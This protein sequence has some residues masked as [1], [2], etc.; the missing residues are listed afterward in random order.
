MKRIEKIDSAM[1]Q[2]IQNPEK[3]GINRALY[4]AYHDSLEKGAEDLDFHEIYKDD[5]EPIVR[6]CR[7][8]GIEQ[9]TISATFSYLTET[10]WEFVVLGCRIDGMKKVPMLYTSYD[11]LTN[12]AYTVSVPGVIIKL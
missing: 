11:S 7:E 6:A 12:T 10:L 2:G 4:W 9:I 8:E 1:E 3:I 5:I